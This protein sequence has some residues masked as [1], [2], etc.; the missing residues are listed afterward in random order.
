MKDINEKDNSRILGRVLA[1]EEVKRISGARNTYID[2]D[3]PITTAE[4][5]SFIW[6]DQPQP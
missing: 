2:I 5:D 4:A 3:Q 1:V 6:W